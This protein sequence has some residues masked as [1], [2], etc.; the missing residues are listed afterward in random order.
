M[1]ALRVQSAGAKLRR[2]AADSEV[3]IMLTN[4][5]QAR[6]ME[7]GISRPDTHMA[8]CNCR[9]RR[10]ERRRGQWRQTVRGYDAEGEAIDLVIVV[11]PDREKRIIVLSGKRVEEDGH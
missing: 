7:D 1:A 3:D 9:I 2:L 8:L 6:L 5:G 10:S 11:D 4:R